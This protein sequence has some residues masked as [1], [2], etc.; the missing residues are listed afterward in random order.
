ML[1]QFSSLF[2]GFVALSEEERGPV[3]PSK[4]LSASSPPYS[5]SSGQ[6]VRLSTQKGLPLDFLFRQPQ[7][8]VLM[9]QSSQR[10]DKLLSIGFLSWFL[11]QGSH[12]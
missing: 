3:W 8:R 4:G 6:G 5:G 10:T 7:D 1:G 2:K 11:H 12:F 9:F